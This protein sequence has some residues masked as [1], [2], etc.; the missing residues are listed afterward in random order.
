MSEQFI[1]KYLESEATKAGL[2][3]DL[4]SLTSRELA[5]ALNRED[6][7]KNLRD[8]FYLPKKG[9]L[10]EADLTL[11]DPDEDSIYLCG[12]SLGLMPKATKEIT[13]EQFDKW[14]KT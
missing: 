10:P 2:P 13:N 12:N 1:S 9:T 11:I 8:E 5:E 6:K 7:L 14:A 4:D 3:I